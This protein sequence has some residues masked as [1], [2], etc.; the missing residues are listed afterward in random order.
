[1]F[2]PLEESPLGSLESQ[3]GQ[4]LNLVSVMKDELNTAISNAVGFS[5]LLPQKVCADSDEDVA[6]RG[7]NAGVGACERLDMMGDTNVLAFG[8][9]GKEKGICIALNDGTHTY[10]LGKLFSLVSFGRMPPE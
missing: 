3:N 2:R 6:T 10:A 5:V 1:M 4:N 8:Y 9:Q 7:G